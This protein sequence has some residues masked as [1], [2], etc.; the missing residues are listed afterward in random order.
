MNSIETNSEQTWTFHP[1]AEKFP[2]MDE[3]AF[4]ELCEDIEANGLRDPITIFEGKILDGRE[5]Y[6]ACMRLNIECPTVELAR[7]LDP[8]AFVISRNIHRRHLNE[9]QR[10]LLLVTHFRFLEQGDVA[11][12]VNDSSHDPSRASRPISVQEAAK[13]A[14][15]S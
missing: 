12:Q 15:V 13:L 1:Y 10:A 4:N 11:T 9:S 5:R 7:N 6:D 2:R 3:K 14:D 8:V